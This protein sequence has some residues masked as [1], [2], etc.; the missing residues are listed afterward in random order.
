MKHR[1]VEISVGINLICCFYIRSLL[2]VLR[3]VALLLIIRILV[4]YLVSGISDPLVL[5]P[6][7]Q[8]SGEAS[9]M[10]A[11]HFKR[12]DERHSIATSNNSTNF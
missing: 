9:S 11:V 5:L 12:L 8:I 4:I 6:C 1:E 7:L 2:P 10:F 3:Y